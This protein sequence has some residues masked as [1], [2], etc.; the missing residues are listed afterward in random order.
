MQQPWVRY[1]LK[2]KIKECHDLLVT[3]PRTSSVSIISAEHLHKEL[4]TH[5]GA[6]TLIRRGY[7]ISRYQGEELE[8]L[9]FDKIKAL[10]E[11]SDPE[12]V[13]GHQSCN[14]FFK[15]LNANDGVTVYC[16]ASYDSLAL[17]SRSSGFPILEKFVV[18]KDGLL[19]NVNE[20]VWDLMV[21]NE[22]KLSWVVSKN[23]PHL[24]WYFERAEGSYT[25]GN[26][27]LFWYGLGPSESLE[28]FIR[29]MV[30]IYSTRASSIFGTPQKSGNQFQKR[31]YS[32]Y[33]Q[34]R[35]S[36]TSMFSNRKKIGIVGA[37]GH[38]GK[39]LINLI[40]RH[41]E[42]ELTHV[43]SREL[44]GQHCAYYTKGNVKYTNIGPREIND[45]EPV[46]CWV[47]ALPNGICKPFVD[48]ILQNPN[49]PAIVDL[50]ADYRFNP[51]WQYG[52]PEL[53]QTRQKF[54]ENSPK[55]ISNPGW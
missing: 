16:D 36:S 23:N 21:K 54:R 53:Y 27:S 43:S 48:T 17:I 18:S 22:E 44:A 31:Q 51:T 4:F 33:V 55:L 19:N 34:V 40:D 2:L 3:L 26:R 8:Y 25:F 39:E 38:T 15:S 45:V 14:Q 50:S 13:S 1:G 35:H 10:L 9:D 32:R 49:H 30:K 42:L 11:E 5:A 29:K 52:V 7:K 12:I 28:N 37:R 6:G 47:M 46:D 20:N 24:T 41:P